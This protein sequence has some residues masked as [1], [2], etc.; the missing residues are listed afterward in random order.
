MQTGLG[1]KIL[2]HSIITDCATLI[3]TLTMNTKKL[4]EKINS[5]KAFILS[6]MPTNI[7]KKNLQG[8]GTLRSLS[9]LSLSLPLSRYFC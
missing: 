4:I 6:Q 8:N 9:F 7:F 1:Q 3:E 5:D 2:L